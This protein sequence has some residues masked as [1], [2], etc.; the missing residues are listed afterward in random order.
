M[1]K[2]VQNAFTVSFAQDPIAHPI[3]SVAGLGG[4]ED[5]GRWND[6]NQITIRFAEDL[7]AA[8]EAQIACGVSSVNIGRVITVLA[9]GCCR[10]LVCSGTIGR[11]LELVRLSFRVRAPARRMEFL[12]PAVEPGGIVDVRPLGFALSSLSII[13]LAP[14]D[15]NPVEAA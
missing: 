5:W 13:P 3:E 11:G 14:A 8:F 6:D 12:I 7:P 15:T 2:R 1:A 9:G 4:A 10:R